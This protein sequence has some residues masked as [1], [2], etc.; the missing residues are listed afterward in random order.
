MMQR[1][2]GVQLNGKG[3]PAGMLIIQRGS[4]GKVFIGVTSAIEMMMDSEALAHSGSFFDADEVH[5]C[6]MAEIYGGDESDKA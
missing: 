1:L 4:D 6:L 5:A 3:K 2:D